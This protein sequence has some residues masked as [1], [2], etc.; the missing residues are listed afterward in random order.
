M[1]PSPD[2]AHEPIFPQRALVLDTET[3]GLSKQDVVVHFGYVYGSVM[4]RAGSEFR[5]SESHEALWQPRDG[6]ANL[7]SSQ[8]SSAPSSTRGPSSSVSFGPV[9]MNP[10]AQA[11]HGIPFDRA[12]QDGVHPA[13]GIR[14]LIERLKALEA[15]GGALVAHNLAFDRRMLLQTARRHGLGAAFQAAFDSVPHRVC[16]LRVLK[17]RCADTKRRAPSLKLEGLYRMIAGPD[18]APGRAHTAIADARMAACLYARLTALDGWVPRPLKTKAASPRTRKRKRLAAMTTLQVPDVPQI[19]RSPAS[20]PES[21][22]APS[23][24]ALQTAPWNPGTPSAPSAAGARP[25]A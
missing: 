4:G 14:A 7:L 9:V 2:R 6:E 15:S 8:D 22:R 21:W 13:G 24:S 16:T 10:R 20:A 25:R 5:I 3:T 17:K 11:V 18:A 23:A 12:M 1:D 19:L